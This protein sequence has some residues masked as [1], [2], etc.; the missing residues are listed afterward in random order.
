MDILKLF[1]ALAT[2]SLMF[3]VGPGRAAEPAVT[4]PD[5]PPETGSPETE[6]CLSLMRIDDS[7]ILD[8]K[9]ML[10]TM[11]DNSMYLNTLPHECAGIRPSDAF[12]FRTSL[13]RLCNQD[14]ITIL[15][16]GGHGMLPGVSCA[17]GLFQQVTPEQVDALK[18]QIEAESK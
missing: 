3:S 16:P 2:I 13:N 11:S 18:L 7:K 17:L 9:H 1:T 15:R 6:F 4:A 12:T 5:A 10:F 14:V 8:S